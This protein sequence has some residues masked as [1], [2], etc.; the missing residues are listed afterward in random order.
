MQN[1]SSIRFNFSSAAILQHRR[2]VYFLMFICHAK[3][4]ASENF[5]SIKSRSSHLRFSIKKGVV[6]NFAKFT[7]N[8]L[9]PSFY[10]NKVA[11]LRPATL[12]KKRLWHRCFPVNFAKFPGKPF[13]QNTSSGC[14]CKSYS[15]GALILIR[16]VFSTQS[17]I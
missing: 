2:F 6:R 5:A 9:C 14:F 7:G 1:V 16:G 13:L 3:F 4:M 17:N 15:S 10:F 8:N 11:G 12:S